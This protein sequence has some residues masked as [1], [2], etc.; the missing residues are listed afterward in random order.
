MQKNRTQAASG[1]YEQQAS[2]PMCVAGANEHCAVHYCKDV[3]LAVNEDAPRITP[4]TQLWPVTARFSLDGAVFEIELQ[5]HE[6]RLGS[7]SIMV[8]DETFGPD[9]DRD[10]EEVIGLLTAWPEVS[11]LQIRTETA[12]PLP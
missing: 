9:S 7:L 3:Y 6:G 8:A 10:H 5:I 12:D 1:P 2:A 11:D 4:R